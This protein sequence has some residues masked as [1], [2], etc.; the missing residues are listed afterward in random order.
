[1]AQLVLQTELYVVPLVVFRGE[2]DHPPAQT[3]R[4]SAF[5]HIGLYIYKKIDLNF[6]SYRHP[7]LKILPINI[8]LWG[9][10][11]QKQS[12][13][14]TPESLLA[15]WPGK[16]AQDSNQEHPAIYH[17]LDVAA[18]A[19]RLLI[20]SPFTAELK[21]AFVL[22]IA[23]HDLGK[24]GD[25]FR[26]LVRL[27]TV[28]TLRHWELTEAWLLP[29]VHLRA[30]LEADDLVWR[31]LVAAIAGH[32]GKPPKQDEKY[33]RR[34]C[35]AQ[36]AQAARDVPVIIDEFLALW[37]HASLAGFTR[38][39]A[40]RL[41]WWLSGLTVVADWVGSNAD[42][43]PA[44]SPV[45]S[46][47]DY[48]ANA[49]SQALHAVQKAGLRSAQL[50]KGELFDF[51]LR[52]MQ[53]AARDIPIPDG[54]MLVFIE[55]ETGAGKTEAALILAQRMLAAGKGRGL[56]FA[57]PT[58]ATADAMFMRAAT[59]MGRLFQTPSLTLAHGRASL[60]EPFRDLIGRSAISDDVVC[61]PW[62]ADSRRRAL[63]ADIGVG[64]IDQALLSVMPTR[65]S[66]L[67]MW[68][69]ASKILL[70]DEAHEICGDNYMAELLA[71]LLRVHA[72]LGGSAILLTATLPLQDRATLTRAFAEGAGHD[73]P[74]DADRSYPAL[75]VPGGAARRDFD[76]RTGSKGPVKV[77]RLA[78]MEGAVDLLATAAASG[79]ACVWVRNAVD[80]A[81]T[82]VEA[83]RARGVAAS[84]LHA[85]FALC[86]RKRI[87]Q[88][89]MTRFGRIGKERAGRVLVATQ[90]VESSLD[91]D[92]DVMVSDLA[93]V[94][95]LIQRAGRLWRHMAERP[96]AKRPVAEP[97]LH[98]LS[99]DPAE[100]DDERWLLDVLGQGAW[101]YPVADQWRTA[102]VLFRTGVIM[103]PTGL[104]DLIEAVRSEAVSVP[105]PLEAAEMERI[106]RGYAESN[107]AMQ[108]LIDFAAGYR[109]GGAA[110]DDTT[111]PTRLGRPTRTLVLARQRGGKLVPWAEGHDAA[112]VEGW[113]LSEVQADAR[114]L[115][116]LQLPDQALP[117]IVAVTRDWPDWRKRS[118]I[119]CPVA[120]DGSIAEGLSYGSQIGLLFQT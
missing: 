68:G 33:F 53:I 29:N 89:E 111:F 28:Q 31:E 93:P 46:L 23:L 61:A 97:V 114:R 67:R 91:L 50:R 102:E 103:S 70:V 16:S 95:A 79:A 52:P 6:S 104:R 10:P 40:K 17:M 57:L 109:R 62:L 78:G 106:G 100:V 38:A 48:L 96:R 22:L 58:M 90:V 75:W 13:N 18:V 85:R 54:P 1:M 63:L 60:S 110:A 65:F 120:G 81:I 14:Q 92:F 7:I 116:R 44:Q 26:N 47:P 69:L 32:H 45:L 55:D 11:L 43:F 71:A 83:L 94:A 76:Q 37:P 59:V 73:V 66:T 3:H 86:D 112:S 105:A 113:M 30:R 88:A 117:E 41:S 24:I 64:T 21:A 34:Y 51:A 35:A 39:E 15:I 74:E 108:N 84:L 98:V 25:G 8:G 27:G 49:R 20:A 77:S 119:V 5:N 12:E 115:D 107:R 118:T 72:A 42:W 101:V 82:A 87:E 56:Y 9:A 19:E 99:P 80:E 2:R 36:G 4:G